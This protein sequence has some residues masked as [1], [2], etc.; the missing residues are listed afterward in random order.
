MASLPLVEP[1][2]SQAELRHVLVSELST[3]VVR[4]ANVDED[5]IDGVMPT[6]VSYTH[7]TLP[8]ISSV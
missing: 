6:P 1:P 5:S 8:T 3:D 2:Q 4:L 7:L